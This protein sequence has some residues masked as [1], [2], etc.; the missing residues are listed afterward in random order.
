VLEAGRRYAAVVTSEVRAQDGRQ[1]A[2]AERFIQIRDPQSTLSDPLDRSARARYAPVLETLATQ[3]VERD[4]VVALAVFRVQTLARDLT[5]ARVLVRSVPAA[6]PV[7]TSAHTEAA[8]DVLLGTPDPGA[9]GL[10]D[11]GPHEHI[12]W[13]IQGHFSAPYLP[14]SQATWHG[15]FERSAAGELLSKTRDE[16]AFTLFLPLGAVADAA[17]PV[18]VVQHGLSGDR[19]D[20][21]PL[22][23]ALAAA[24]YAVFAFDAPFHGLRAAGEDLR[25]RFTGAAEPDGFGDE[26]GDFIGVADESGS[27]AAFHP[28]YVR[29][30]VRQGAVELMAAFQL[31]EDAEL[32]RLQDLDPAL[33]SVRFDR[34]HIGF[35]GTDLGA[36]LGLLVAPLEP[37]LSSVVLAFAGGAFVDGWFESPAVRPLGDALLARLGRDADHVDFEHDSPLLLPDLDAFRALADRAGGLANAAALR[38][39][40]TH[41]LLLMAVDDEVVH[42]RSTEVLA[43]ALGATLAGSTPRFVPE[44]P[45]EDFRPGG[46]V[47][48]NLALESGA[49]TRVLYAYD[50][51]THEALQRARSSR[52]FDAPLDPPFFP[53]RTPFEVRN[54]IASLLRQITFYFESLRACYATEPEGPEGRVSA[55]V[56]AVRLPDFAVE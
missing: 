25:N 21:V 18:I 50:P 6:P 17:L 23:D 12:A 30:A 34:K 36:E 43:H 38:R 46:T 15:A 33:E 19:S 52:H 45:S 4:E 29:D 44:L 9:Q 31:L 3:G 54:P 37:T 51:A 48:G 26:P 14:A 10:D 56:P 5:D 7:L 16:V 20:A 49:V 27:L 42:N 39:S 22:A 53:R 13:M 11:G 1:V 41:V 28:F 2:A 32:W 35:V 55:C 24:G 40:S 47:S 8:L